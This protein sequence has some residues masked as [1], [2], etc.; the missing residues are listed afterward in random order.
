MAVIT[1]TALRRLEKTGYL[2]SGIDISAAPVDDSFNAT[3]T[4]LTGLLNEQ[5]VSVAGFANAANNGFFEVKGSSTAGKVLQVTPSMTHFRL[6]GAAGNFAS[7]PDSAAVSITGSIEL[8]GRAAPTSYTGAV[9]VVIAKDDGSTN[10]DY[11]LFIDAAGKL[12]FVY[13]TDGSTVTGRT[14]TSTAVIPFSALALSF[15][16]ATYN[17]ATGAVQ[18]FTSPDGSVYTQLGTTVTI[19]A[20]AIHN[21]TGTLTVGANGAGANRLTGRVYYAEVRNGIGGIVVASFS[22]SLGLRDDVSVTAATGEI[23]T[24]NTSGTPPSILQGS[25]LV[26]E[27]AGPTVVLTGFRRGLGQSYQMEFVAQALDRGNKSVRTVNQPM[28]DVMPEVILYREENTDQVMTS[29]IT[30][31][32]LGQWREMLSST[33]AGESIVFDKYGTIAAPDNPLPAM[34]VSESYTENRE[35]AS[36]IG[37]QFVYRIP[38]Q[39]R[40]FV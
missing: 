6:S 18:F 15:L 17:T 36:F 38:F 12:N 4:V 5:W 14:A 39:L 27:A 10:R 2:K 34:V 24:L 9:Q 25:A 21:G 29:V 13:S 19:T 1:Y 11:N 30:E 20:G 32:G 33:S 23:W 31:S 37:G 35:A 7:T 40:V 3:T 16:K 8:M 26:T 28:D 22:P